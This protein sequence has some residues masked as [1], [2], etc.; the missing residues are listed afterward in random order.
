MKSI[1]DRPADSE[2]DILPVAYRAFVQR[3]PPKV[4]KAKGRQAL[5]WPESVLVFD[6]E[7]TTD[8]TQRLLF[9]SYRFG[10]WNENGTFVC[11]EEGFFHDDALPK[12]NPAGWQCLQEYVDSRRADTL[13]RRRPE[14]RLL[15]RREFVNERLWKAMEG[16]TLIVGYNLPFDLTR[17]AISAG[18][19][20]GPMF[21]GG[22]SIAHF[23]YQ[24]AS[25]SWRE[26][27]YR[28]RFRLKALDSKRALMGLAQRRGARPEERRDPNQALGRFLDL[29]GLVF[30][31]TDKHLSL[32]KAAERFGLS[33]RKLVIQTHG[34]LTTQSLDYNRQDVALTAQLLE[35]VRAEWDRH[36][37]ALSPDRVMSP[38]GLAKG[39]LRALGV[40]PPAVKFSDVPPNVLGVALSAYYGGRTE[41]RVRRTPVP[42]VHLDFLSMYPTVNALMEL[43]P[44]LIA[45]RLRVVDA[46]A[47]VR[48][49]GQSLSLER[50]FSKDF[51][52]ELRFFARIRPSGDV[53]PVRAQYD[54]A[55]QTTSIGVN[56]VWSDEPVWVAGPDLV[57]S[58]L[59]TG[60]CPDVEEAIE[61]V[62]V[63]RQAGLAPVALRGLIPIDPLKDDFFR[64]VIEARYEIRRR[65]NLPSEERE[66]LQRFLKV[67]ANSGSY[68]IF[69]ELNVQPPVNETGDAVLVFGGEAPFP[70]R[71]L[72]P[73][74]PGEFCFPPFAA[75]TTSAARLMLALLERSVDDRGGTIAFGDTDSAAIVA[76]PRGGLVPCPGGPESKRDRTQ[77]V[78]ALSWEDVEQIR[79]AFERLNPY[80]PDIVDGSILRREEVNFSTA[81]TQRT[82]YAYAISAKRYALFTRDTRDHITIVAR[83]EHGLGHLRNPADVDRDD[84]D[85]ITDVWTALVREA[86]GHPLV[87]P[88]WVHQPAVSRVS[89]STADL[90]ATFDTLNVGRPYADQIK[91]TNFGLSVSTAPLGYPIGVDPA[92]FH[93]V[94]GYEKDPARW[95]AMD[96]LNKYGGETYRI[97][98]GRD[99]PADRVQ[100]K[101][102]LDVVMEYRTHPEPKSLGTDGHPCDRATS[103]LLARRPVRVGVKTYIGKESNRLEDVLHGLVHDVRDVQAK[104]TDVQQ[105]PWRHV[106]VPF[107]RRLPRKDIARRARLTPR[108]VQASRN[109]RT[110]SHAT[111]KALLRVALERA[112]VVLRSAKADPELRQLADR[113]LRSPVAAPVLTR[114]E[115]RA[116]RKE[117]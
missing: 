51:W 23:E 65:I 32:D 54:P 96:W 91:P 45:E 108:T 56:P 95:L 112:R 28:P 2:A 40:T 104:Y 89:V 14:I 77:A 34:D 44:L 25:G 113:L 12:M 9:G 81:G 78:R 100:V 99:A 72:A 102:Y 35:A 97:A 43:W 7:T 86:L 58:W 50:C 26:N 75:L 90:W 33:E 82:I 5:G 79:A 22:F 41:V 10:H 66:R 52:T 6:T 30:A 115:P 87:W 106:V 55:A 80:D 84:I 27:P 46:T 47:R 11:L 24:D 101:S 67:L 21:G 110:P 8:P 16:G 85:W 111:R 117:Q 93:L 42:V 61:L 94:A 36:P 48:Q 57:A 68:G 76:L 98:I 15:S 70:S 29:K 38:A 88:T 69:A 71:T 1:A 39:Y 114:G 109:D 60:R 64:R 20:R 18:P 116:V 107:L 53:L 63:G 13:N 37:L 74:D 19:A 73:E 83:K 92:R 4:S 3:V 17:I 59:L 103:G 62:P 105:D 31:L 49:L